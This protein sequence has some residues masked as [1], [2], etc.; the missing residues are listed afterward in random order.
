MRDLLVDAVLRGVK[1]ATCRLQV[2]DQMSDTPS[3]TPGTR[4][5]LMNSSG[6]PVATV[7]IRHV[8]HLALAEVG[9]SVVAAE[10]DWF[11]G[12]PAWRTAHERFWSSSLDAIREYLGDPDWSIRDHTVVTVRF[13]DLEH[14]AETA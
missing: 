13:F 9:E 8:E 14:P 7:V 10:G 5:E 4:M 1:T 11:D 12:V 3:E 6:E 2:M